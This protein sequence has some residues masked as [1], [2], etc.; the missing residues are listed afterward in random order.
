MASHKSHL[1]L[2]DFDE[3][4]RVVAP[5]GHVFL[6]QQC[7]PAGR[8]LNGDLKI[9]SGGQTGADRAALD[10]AIK[11]K[12][13]CGGWCPEDRRAEDGPIAER[14]PLTPLPGAGYRQ[15]TR[16]NVQDSDGTAIF[17]F[18]L[19]T[20]G[21]KATAKFCEQNEKPCLIV[22]AQNTTAVEAAILVAV[23]LLRHRIHT[24]NIAGPRASGQPK[25]YGFVR[26][27]MLKLLS[28]PK[29]RRKKPPM[30]SA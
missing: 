8:P 23:F 18:G 3:L 14:Y 2:A 12:I 5:K 29:K 24:L 27:V 19:L 9:I 1:R 28:P 11:L 10:V 20:G 6:F 15:R 17:S 26:D 7:A 4:S 25:I 13:P 21:S 22:D 16:K 30:L